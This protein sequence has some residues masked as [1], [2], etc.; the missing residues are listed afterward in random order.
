MIRR[1]GSLADTVALCV[2]V[3]HSLEPDVVCYTVRHPPNTVKNEPKTKVHLIGSAADPSTSKLL[4]ARPSEVTLEHLK[5][6]NPKLGGQAGLDGI[7]DNQVILFWA[8][9]AYFT[10]SARQAMGRGM[11]IRFV[12]D[13]S[14]VNV[15]R[16]SPCREDVHEDGAGTKNRR[17]AHLATCKQKS[18][19]SEKMVL[20]LQPGRPGDGV[21]YRSD[22][23]VI[24]EDNWLGAKP[25]RE[26]V[27]LA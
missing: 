16:I 10:I 24:E 13:S 7:P 6:Q 8:E 5:K 22:M 12:Y 19:P 3:P 9:C 17:F 20:M 27:A 11:F 18:I 14:G 21:W 1:P 26:L 2:C 25:K 4:K 23:A 15:G